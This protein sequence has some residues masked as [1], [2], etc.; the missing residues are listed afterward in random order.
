MFFRTKPQQH[1]QSTLRGSHRAGRWRLSPGGLL[2]LRGRVRIQH[3]GTLHPCS[4]CV[5]AGSDGLFFQSTP[6]PLDALLNPKHENGNSH[7]PVPS[8]RDTVLRCP[9]PVRKRERGRDLTAQR[10]DWKSLETNTDPVDSK[11]EKR[12]R[13]IQGMWKQD[14]VSPNVPSVYTGN[15]SWD[16]LVFLI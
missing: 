16:Q 10:S 7:T 11:R 2:P 14:A 3:P 1:Y 12:P 8:V 9:P 15:V 4:D 6:T 5:H 13:C